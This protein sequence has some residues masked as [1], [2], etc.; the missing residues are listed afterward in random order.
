[1]TSGGS[2]WLCQRYPHGVHNTRPRNASAK[3]RA[4]FGSRQT[5]RVCPSFTATPEKRNTSAA[6]CQRPDR[7]KGSE[8]AQHGGCYRH[9][10]PSLYD[11]LSP[12][13]VF[14]AARLTNPTHS[15]RRTLCNRGEVADLLHSTPVDQGSTRG[16]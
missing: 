2:P 7:K 6:G 1:M 8:I 13:C 16:P 12:A 15:K 14:E 5:T 10:I 4:N 9:Q 11:T 3:V